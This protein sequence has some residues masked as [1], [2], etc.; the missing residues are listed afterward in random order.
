MMKK[1]YPS[2]GSAE[3]EIALM[4]SSEPHISNPK[5]HC[6]PTTILDVPDEEGVQLLVMP[7]LLS[8][9]EPKFSTV[10][11]V[12]DFFRQVFEVSLPRHSLLLILISCFRGPSIHAYQWRS[13][14]VRV[15][16][17]EEIT[18]SHFCRDCKYDNILMNPTGLYS[19]LPHPMDSDKARDFKSKPSHTTRTL[20]PV[21]YY[22][23]DFGHAKKYDLSVPPEE[24]LERPKWGAGDRT[25]PEFKKDELCDP[26]AV[27]VYCIG[28]LILSHFLDV[29]TLIIKQYRKLRPFF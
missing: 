25:I 15:D 5:N 11:E 2:S 12:L 29:R 23:I 8:W 21:R 17:P 13:S 26:F 22:F 4:F 3:A 18:S 1:F 28:H 24:R 10:G 7:L 9:E 27:D 6:V 16:N 14:P 20:A 19:I